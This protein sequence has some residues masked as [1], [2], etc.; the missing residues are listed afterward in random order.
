MSR[1]LSLADTGK[2][3]GT[4]AYTV[5]KIERNPSEAKIKDLKRICEVLDL[6]LSEIIKLI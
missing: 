1:G 4:S 6:E 5:S 3:M 2:I